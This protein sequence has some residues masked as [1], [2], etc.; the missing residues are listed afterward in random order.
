[1]QIAVRLHAV[2]RDL[3][4]GGRGEVEVSEGATVRD[5]LDQLQ[6]EDELRE[7]ITVNGEQVRDLTTSLREGD[8]VQVFPAVAG[9][10]KRS[11]YL[12]EGIRLFN[13]GD[14][15]MAH[16]TLEEHWIEAPE[17]ER[18]FYQALIHLAVGFHHYERENR[19]GARSQ[20]FKAAKRLATY[21]DE[22]E[23]VDVATVRR[24][25][26]EAQAK[27]DKEEPLEPPRLEGPA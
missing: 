14:Y 23:G 11:P 27:L 9:G 6:V 15:F 26:E 24:F 16:E 4:P 18:D 25:L 8:E 21:P 3:I 22:H 2:L 7:L 10:A 1:M 5:L 20:F 12:D 19:N 17:S 13:A